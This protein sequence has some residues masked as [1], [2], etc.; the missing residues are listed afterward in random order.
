ML[1]KHFSVSRTNTNVPV[2]QWKIKGTGVMCPWD[3]YLKMLHSGSILRIVGSSTYSYCS[4]WCILALSTLTDTFTFSKPSSE[5]VVLQTMCL[6]DLLWEEASKYKRGSTR[7][8]PVRTQLHTPTSCDLNLLTI[9]WWNSLLQEYT[10]Y[11]VTNS[12]WEVAL[13]FHQF[14]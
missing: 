12:S 6:V 13:P 1:G 5:A 3:A 7:S 10:E 9:K 2:L 14:K 4:S 8:K 11:C